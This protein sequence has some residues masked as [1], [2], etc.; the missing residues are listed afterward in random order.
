MD[1]NET[2]KKLLRI[3]GQ[4]MRDDSEEDI[5]FSKQQA[6]IELA[7]GISDLDEWLAKGGFL[8]ERWSESR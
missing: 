8:P 2:L 7:E 5:W 1:P 3:A 6:A 4:V